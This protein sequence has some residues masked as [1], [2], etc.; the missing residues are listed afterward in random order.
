M[1]LQIAIIYV[2]EWRADFICPDFPR[3]LE[4]HAV[5]FPA[6]LISILDKH[7]ADEYY[8]NAVAEGGTSGPTRKHYKREWMIPGKQFR[9]WYQ[10]RKS[11]G[12][13]ARP[14][15]FL[16]S[17]SWLRRYAV[18][19]AHGINRNQIIMRDIMERRK[20]DKAVP[21]RYEIVT[22]PQNVKPQEAS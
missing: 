9:S 20:G 22:R 21:R 17:S 15:L 12:G 4:R 1:P 7:P 2:Q 19:V 13:S 11:T 16:Y 18:D 5:I 6:A 14:L 10:K 3:S 8:I